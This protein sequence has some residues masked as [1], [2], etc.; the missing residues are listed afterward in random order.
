MIKDKSHLPAISLIRSKVGVSRR[1]L[2]IHNPSEMSTEMV[3]E[4]LKIIDENLMIINDS[5]M[6]LSLRL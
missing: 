1:L 4:L 2:E 6:E 5:V 3:S